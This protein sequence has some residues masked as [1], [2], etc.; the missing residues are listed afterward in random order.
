MH[1]Y[2]VFDVSKLVLCGRYD[3]HNS[4]LP[5]CVACC[6]NTC[7]KVLLMCR[8]ELRMQTYDVT[9]RGLAYSHDRV[10]H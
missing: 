1:W 6:C 9:L 10:T 7:C 3:L 4:A 2:E 8:A 5:I